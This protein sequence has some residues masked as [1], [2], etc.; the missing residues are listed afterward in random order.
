MDQFGG[1]SCP[2]V[3]V[4]L[5]ESGQV[6]ES[7][8]DESARRLLHDKFRLGLFDNPFVD[9]A[10]ASSI[11]G[12]AD[13]KA[14]GELAQRKS[15]VLL[16]NTALPA[17][18][19]LPVQGRPRLYVEGISA[20]AA[21]DYG[22]AVDSPEEAD[23]AILRLR[24][25]FEPRNRYFLEPMFHAGSLEFAEDEKKRIQAIATKVPTIV[26]IYLDRPSVIPEIAEASAALLAN[27]GANERALLD[28]VFGRFAPSGKLPFELPSSAEAVL[29]QKSDMPYDSENPLFPF[30]FGLTY[31]AQ[32]QS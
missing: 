1:E 9:A 7:R 20:E 25:P 13:F 30:G 29:N 27:F 32:P 15:F 17:G 26:D 31:A 4:E 14:A 2:E 23:L 10:A 16:K 3:I 22:Q 8:I 5:V 28:V 11:V 19:I 24:A 12:R 21:A 6:P 18:T